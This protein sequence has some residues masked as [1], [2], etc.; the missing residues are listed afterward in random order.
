M[1]PGRAARHDY[2][3]ERRGVASLFLLGEPLRGRR[4]VVVTERRTR[5]DRAHVVRELADVHYPAAEQIVLV[6]DNLNT[7]TPTALYET[8]P[9]AEAKR[10]LDR[11][12]LHHTPKHGSWL[13]LAEVELAILTK[14][15]LSGRIADADSLRERVSAWF[16]PAPRGAAPSAGASRPRTPGSSSPVSTLHFP[17]DNP[18]AG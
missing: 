14:Q 9:L 6:Q 1:A 15:V 13:N 11:L 8:S 16:T 10:L 7:R 5:R 2:E 4:R 12:A 18:L 17:S 3:Y